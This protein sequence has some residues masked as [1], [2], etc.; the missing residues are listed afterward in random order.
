MPSLHVARPILQAGK[1]RWQGHL[2][3]RRGQIAFA[4]RLGIQLVAQDP[5][6][7][8][9]PRWSATRSVAEGLNPLQPPC[10]A[11]PAIKELLAEGSL[12]AELASRRPAGLSG[13]QAQRV[14]IARALA[15]GRLL[16]GCDDGRRARAGTVPAEVKG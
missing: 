14:A 5:V 9:D 1:V 3:G 13:G 2:L 12:D 11:D 7:S 15:A 16:R 6:D 4:Y 10:A 8:L